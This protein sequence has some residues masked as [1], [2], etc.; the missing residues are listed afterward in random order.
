M[1]RESF[2]TPPRI[3]IF[4]NNVEFGKNLASLSRQFAPSANR[5]FKFNKRS[6]LLIRTHN[7]RFRRRDVRQ[8]R[9]LFALWNYRP[10]DGL[11]LGDVVGETEGVGVGVEAGRG[12]T[13]TWDSSCAIL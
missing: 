5:R 11:G 8:R 1:P 3:Q 2:L 12:T 9:R 13:G 6:Q 7:E 4:L 10:G